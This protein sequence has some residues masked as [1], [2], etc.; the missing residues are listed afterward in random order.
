MTGILG[1]KIIVDPTGTPTEVY[2]D[3]VKYI[4]DKSV[5]DIVTHKSVMTGH[6]EYA[7]KG[8]HWEF[9]IEMNFYK[10][11]DQKSMYNTLYPYWGTDVYLYRHRD[12]EAMKDAAGNNVLFTFTEITESYMQT[13]DFKDLL[14]LCFRSKDYVGPLAS[15]A[16]INPQLSEIVIGQIQQ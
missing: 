7:V 4:N 6:T 9:D 14:T 3:F 1:P 15:S 2:L 13:P 16:V 5:P 8:R 12:G 10:Y 11:S